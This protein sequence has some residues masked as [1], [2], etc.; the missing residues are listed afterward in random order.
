MAP[1]AGADRPQFYECWIQRAVQIPIEGKDESLI[2][3]LASFSNSLHRPK[4]HGL[5]FEFPS[6]DF[7]QEGEA[8]FHQA[9]VVDPGLLSARAFSGLLQQDLAVGVVHLGGVN[10]R[11]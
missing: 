6:F 11:F 9:V 8:D 4:P 2:S 5:G 1:L 3:A 7:G 10:S